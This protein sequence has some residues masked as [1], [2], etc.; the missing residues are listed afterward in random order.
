MG[1]F[2]V[3]RQI[4]KVTFR[5]GRFRDPCLLMGKP[6]NHGLVFSFVDQRF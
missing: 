1:I 5:M 6:K 2:V 3:S 4:S